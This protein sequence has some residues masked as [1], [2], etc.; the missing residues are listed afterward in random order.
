MTP[1]PQVNYMAPYLNTLSWPRDPGSIGQMSTW[2]STSSNIYVCI[3]SVYISCAETINGHFFLYLHQILLFH[4]VLLNLCHRLDHFS[5]CF[6]Y[7][8]FNQ[9]YM[10]AELRSVCASSWFV[11]VKSK[12]RLSKRS[13]RFFTSNT[14]KQDG[15]CFIILTKVG[16]VL[17]SACWSGKVEIEVF[18]HILIQQWWV[19][20]L[21]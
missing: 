19:R 16:C 4:S 7:W 1:W 20:G 11:S 15:N 21:K 13:Q 17:D 10:V 14:A 6:L 5:M 12:P 8:L 3:C 18:V 2:Q 9:C